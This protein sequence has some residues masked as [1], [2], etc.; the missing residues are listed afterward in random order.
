M[1]LGLWPFNEEWVMNHTTDR[2]IATFE[3]F[4]FH[5]AKDNVLVM[6]VDSFDLF[7]PNLF[8]TFHVMASY[9]NRRGTVS[10]SA[11]AL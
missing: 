8:P 11:N 10:L 6:A 5:H 4:I 7:A 1:I 3:V 2:F 9:L